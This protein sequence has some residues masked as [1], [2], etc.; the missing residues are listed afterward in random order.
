MDVLRNTLD[1]KSAAF[2]GFDSFDPSWVNPLTESVPSLSW[3]ADPLIGCYNSQ[4]SFKQ[5][6]LDDVCRLHPYGITRQ[7]S[8]GWFF[9]QDK[10]LLHEARKYGRVSRANPF[11]I[12]QTVSEVTRFLTWLRE[13]PSRSEVCEHLTT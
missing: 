9:N 12:D 6:G 8:A 5:K 2:V 11:I 3:M 13:R 10:M 1:H 7:S 4:L